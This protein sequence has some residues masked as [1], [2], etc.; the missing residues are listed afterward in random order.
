MVLET[1]QLI[2]SSVYWPDKPL[3]VIVSLLP[4]AVPAAAAVV[5]LKAVLA[6]RKGDTAGHGAG[7]L[8]TIG[9]TVPILAAIALYLSLVGFSTFFSFIFP[10]LVNF[11]ESV[12]IVKMLAV[13]LLLLIPSTASCWGS[14][15]PKMAG[16]AA[17]HLVL[18]LMF[19]AFSNV[20]M[21][22]VYFYVFRL[23]GL[24]GLSYIIALFI[25]IYGR[26]GVPWFVGGLIAL[27]FYGL[28]R[29]LIAHLGRR[30][31]ERHQPLI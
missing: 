28:A 31:I 6:L 18:I 7:R 29:L 13:L 11:E 16:V 25:S 30:G 26:L 9:L 17:V 22:E 2:E 15:Y 5:F 21:V 4:V 1:F 23:S 20:S 3:P 8:V 10:G 24:E 19:N 27:P 12:T 14:T